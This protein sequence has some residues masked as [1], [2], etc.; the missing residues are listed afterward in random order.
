MN[1]IKI[2]VKRTFFRNSKK[3]LFLIFGI[4]A[5]IVLLSMYIMR[6]DSNIHNRNEELDSLAWGFSQ[7]TYDV[8]MEIIDYL[9]GNEEIENVE[10]IVKLETVGGIDNVEWVVSADVPETWKFRLL[11]G[12]LPE[13]GEILLTE[14]ASLGGRQPI[15][16][17]KVKVEVKVGEEKHQIEAVISG[18][19]EAFDGFTDSYAF[20]YSEDFDELDRV[21]EDEERQYDVFYAYEDLNVDGEA[22]KEFFTKMSPYRHSSWGHAGEEL[23]Y[24]W[25]AVKE[26]ILFAL[27]FG[28]PCI[29]AIIYMILQD[30]KKNIGILRALG[31]KKVQIATMLT[32]RIL[33]SGTIGI[34]LGGLFSFGVVALQKKLMYSE[35]V[36]GGN[37]G[38]VSI[39]MIPLVGFVLLL[40]LQIPGVYMLLRETPV[41]LLS[42]VCH[43][44]ENLIKSNGKTRMEIKHPIWWYA[45]LEGK[46]LR[47]QRIGLILVTVLGMLLPSTAVMSLRADLKDS[48]RKATE[49]TYTIGKVTG[50]LEKEEMEDILGIS[51]VISAGFSVKQ[52][53]TGIAKY[54]GENETVQL[55]ILD[56][57]SFEKMKKEYEALGIFIEE[58]SGEELLK[59]GGILIRRTMDTIRKQVEEGDIVQVFSPTGECHECEIV[60]VGKSS[61][62]IGFDYHL[63]LSFEKYFEI[64]GFPQMQGM[65]ACLNGIKMKDV[66]NE[67]QK[68]GTDI[69]IEKNEIL[70]G[71]TEEELSS[72][73]WIS[74]IV[75]LL[76]GILSTVAFFF[77]Y[78]S[79]YYLAKTEEYRKLFAMGA[80]KG[81]IRDIMVS[82]SLR[83]SLLLALFS[84]VVGYLLYISDNKAM[85]DQWFVQNA[86]RVP[87]AELV[88]IAFLV[89]GISMGATSFA[90][91]QVLK[92]LEQTA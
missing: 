45:G 34:L 19:V 55:Q 13:K 43:I 1:Y 74:N 44:G 51:G 69:Y 25:G 17:E 31:A 72:D 71:N 38:W 47:G 84:T 83:N 14:S 16:G 90:S 77:C 49:E 57:I 36:A 48:G 50:F 92:E 60:M 9:K 59:N 52:T 76:L 5:F 85:T 28:G 20:L 58:E 82:Q 30:E 65:L 41:N 80:S 8:S 88:V 37:T 32:A 18:V 63:F 26:G 66:E 54:D 12:E 42:G 21:L 64:F 73:A 35:T 15:S 6:S 33:V 11:Y 40:V 53:G 75:T 4:A 62:E 70:Y 7:K 86:P 27:I 87:V 78:Y 89:V 2:Y 46:R 10:P 91:K 56:E 79:F 68:I 3:Q 61:G 39:V 81:M 29:G 22:L 24:D 67:L 23:V